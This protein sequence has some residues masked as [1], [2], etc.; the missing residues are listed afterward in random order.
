MRGGSFGTPLTLVTALVLAALLAISGGLVPGPTPALAQGTK[1]SAVPTP[2]AVVGGVYA[3]D[4]TGPE[5]F[6]TGECPGG[7]ALGVNVGEG[8]KFTVRGK[9][10]PDQAQANVAQLGRGIG[11]W[12]GDAALDFKVV[13]GQE[14]AT[15]ALYA[16]YLN[17]NGV[18][19]RVD[20]GAGELKLV[21]RKDGDMATL[22][23]RAD[24]GSLIDASNWNRLAFRAR[25]GEVW[26]LLNDVPVLYAA[27][28]IDQVGMVGI[29]VLRDGSPDDDDEVSVVFR[30]LT[31]SKVVD[32][33]DERAPVYQAPS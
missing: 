12:D 33:P 2:P 4:L 5:I 23:S 3:N 20:V 13:V 14:R 28:T 6:P 8:F 19:A 32:S 29:Q 21:Q 10:V 22:A 7:K 24:L 17:R 27:D 26:L 15:I 16:R 9:C 30:D 11:F 18:E 1:P 25:G 31:L